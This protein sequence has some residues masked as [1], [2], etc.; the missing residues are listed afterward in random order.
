MDVDF[1]GNPFPRLLTDEEITFIELDH[2]EKMANTNTVEER[3]FLNGTCINNTPYRVL[4]YGP[5]LPNDT[6]DNS[7]FYFEGGQTSPVG[8][9][10]DGFYIPVNRSLLIGTAE[11]HSGVGAGKILD[12]STATLNLRT[13]NQFYVD[14]AFIIWRAPGTVNWPFPTYSQTDIDGF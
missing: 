14:A 12:V 4:F 13:S 1:A 7:L 8:W 5:R 10:C 2:A 6:T 11:V 9:D 3:N